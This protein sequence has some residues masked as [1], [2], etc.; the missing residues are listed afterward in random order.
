MNCIEL[1]KWKWT[2]MRRSKICKVSLQTIKKQW[3]QSWLRFD[4]DIWRSRFFLLA[5]KWKLLKRFFSVERKTKRLAL[6]CYLETN[7]KSRIFILLRF[8]SF[9]LNK[10]WNSQSCFAEDRPFAAMKHSHWTT[11]EGFL[12]KRRKRRKFISPHKTCHYIL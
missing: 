8:I 6:C 7:C 10:L 1:K 2:L 3:F 5:C 4:V 11:S 9:P 12:Q